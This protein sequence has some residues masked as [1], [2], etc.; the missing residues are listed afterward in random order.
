M[1]QAVAHVRTPDLPRAA[2]FAVALA[3][4]SELAGCAAWRAAFAGLRK[5][6]R[7][8]EI[9]EE[10]LRNDFTYRYLT[11]TDAAGTVVAVQPC[12]LLDQDLLEGLGAS[13]GRLA[14]RV[15]RLYPRFLKL[16]TLMLGCAAGEGHLAASDALPPARVADILSRAITGLAAQC[17]ARMIVLKEFPDGDRA[18]LGCFQR[19]GFCR[20]PGMPMTRLDIRYD[21]FEHFLQALPSSARCKLRKNLR[22]TAGEAIPMTVTD[23]VDAVVDEVY[24]LYLQV[25]GRSKLHFETLERD[26]FLRLGREMPD[27]CLFFVWRRGGRAVA[28]SHM[29]LEG[30]TL[31]S[32]YIGL[33]YDVALD[34]HLYFC[35][36]RDT[37]RWAIANG[38]RSI[39]SSPLNYEPKFRLRHTLVPVDLYVRHVS[40]LANRALKLVLPWLVP[41]R[42]DKVLRRFANYRDLW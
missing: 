26:Y 19:R 2:P 16:R 1:D 38:F 6:H 24:P 32:E 7:Y 40:P 35:V 13:V 28:F 37:I 3:T 36:V 12:F 15:R 41:A 9:L 30:D 42:Y 33:D 11:I 14:G 8:Y 23:N 20:V 27:K 25:Y 39:R 10:T 22:A 34:L 31:F 5:D 29:M 17:G 18:A 21:S 4:R